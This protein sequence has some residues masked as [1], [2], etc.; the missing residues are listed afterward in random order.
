ML[1]SLLEGIKV[2]HPCDNKGLDIL[3]VFHVNKRNF[4]E[5]RKTGT[6]QA[7]ILDGDSTP[8][9]W[10]NRCNGINYSG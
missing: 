2:K 4:E 9:T 7:A 5:T 6:T 3:S 8:N 10:G 1:K